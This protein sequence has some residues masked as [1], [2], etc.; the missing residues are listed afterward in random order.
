MWMGR[1][2]WHFGQRSDDGVYLATAKSIATGQ[3]YRLLH[4]PGA[5]FAIKYPPLYPAYLSLAWIIQPAFPASARV[6]AVLH[7]ALVPVYVALLLAMLLQF[8]FSLRRIFLVAALS[9]VS[10]QV[11]ALTITLFSELLCMCLL[12]ACVLAGERSVRSESSSRDSLRWALAAGLFAG[13]AYLTRTAALPIFAAVPLFYILRKRLRLI[14][15]FLLAALPLAAGWHLWILTHTAAGPTTAT[16]GYLTEYIRMIRLKGFW[17]NFMTQ[18]AAVSAGVTEDFMPG[19]IAAMFGLP[20][21]HI[22]FAA[23]ISGC[24]RMGRRCGWP[25]YLVFSGL[26]CLMIFLWWSGGE[27]VTRLVLPIWPALMAGIAEEASHVAGLFEQT[28]AKSQSWMQK[29]AV[30]RQI[31]RWALIGLGLLTI[32]RD[33]SSAWSW[34][35]TALPDEHNARLQ[36]EVAFSWIASHKTPDTVVLAWKDA[37]TFL[38][39]GAASSRGLFITATP[40]SP[41]TKNF[42]TSFADLSPAY[43]RCLMLILRS[44][45]GG[46]Q[47][48]IDPLKAA[49]LALPDAKLEFTSPGGFIYSFTVPRASR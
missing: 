26:Y 36:D 48:D 9:L 37:T 2:Q 45:L 13:L 14:P 32:F 11:V 17:S 25:L 47:S 40:Q 20:L 29:S 1:E 19:F 44:D 21:F 39:T 30:W 16:A 10:M 41:Q 22:V 4:L 49:A 33:G 24:V 34:A 35:A 23:A 46:S 18:I 27:G 31:P 8:G 15:Y 28:M 12:F 7:A 43:T 5:P 3:G 6:A 42:A 38:Y